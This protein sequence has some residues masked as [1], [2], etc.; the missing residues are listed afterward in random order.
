MDS[1]DMDM[2]EG[3][4]RAS[5]PTI[6]GMHSMSNFRR[7]YQA[8]GTY[9]FT[10]VSKNRAPIFTE[11][12]VWALLKEG[13]SLARANRPFEIDSL[14]LLPDHLHTIWTLPEGD[15]NYSVRWQEIKRWVSRQLGHSIW[16]PR[17]WEHTIRDER[18]FQQ[19]MD[20]VH[21]NPV[22]HGLSNTAADW[23][24]STF[25]RHVKLGNYPPDWGGANEL[26]IPYDD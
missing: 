19:H 15:F 22:K 13:I 10:V 23:A 20:Y 2:T 1:N 16:Q 6:N 12:H 7:N 3:G 11:P 25:H 5:R 18:D 9:F 17:F 8:G 4:M 14:V 24:Y 26:E 21:Y